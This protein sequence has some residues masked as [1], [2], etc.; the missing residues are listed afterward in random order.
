[1]SG[2][3]GAIYAVL[4]GSV[5]DTGGFFIEVGTDETIFSKCTSSDKGGAIYLEL[6]SGTETKYSLIGVSYST[7]T[8]ANSA[9]F[10]NNLFIKASDL[11]AAVPIHTT[12]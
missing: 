3:G 5:A 10:G 1:L 9:T 4:S 11:Q 7:D 6:G 12:E 8:N 2:N